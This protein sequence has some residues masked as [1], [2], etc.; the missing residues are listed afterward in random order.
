MHGGVPCTSAA[1]G[2]RCG[3]CASAPPSPR[4]PKATLPHSPLAVGRPP[5]PAAAPNT[6]YAFTHGPRSA[7][8]PQ[9]K[10]VD[11]PAVSTPPCNIRPSF[12]PWIRVHSRHI[13]SPVHVDAAV[14]RDE[15]H[16]G[17][18]VHV[19]CTAR[20]AVR[21]GAARAVG[22]RVRGQ[23][24]GRL[25][26][27]S[28]T[29]RWPCSGGC[30]GCAVITAAVR[31]EESWVRTM[32]YKR[33]S[34]QTRVLSHRVFVQPAITALHQPV[35]DSALKGRQWHSTRVANVCM[36]ANTP[37]HGS[38]RSCSHDRKERKRSAVARPKC[39]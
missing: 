9:P 10:P 37:D 20:R 3:R 34:G 35:H 11:S 33:V 13:D 38:D 14:R 22:R 26:G 30:S 16:H 17:H 18:A 28:R 19:V 4:L 36:D 27:S 5:A 15:R 31:L 1:N 2:G 25:R 24:H 32:P 29:S 8:P 39:L 6:C 7:S 21:H 12:P 23:E